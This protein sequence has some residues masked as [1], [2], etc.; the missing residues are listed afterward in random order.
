MS[1]Q[2]RVTRSLP[3]LLFAFHLAGCTSW[4]VETLPPTELI[5][6]KHPDRLR[7]EETDGRRVMFYGPDVQADSLRGRPSATATESRSVALDSVRSVST[8]RL[9]AGKTILLVLGVPVAVL[10]AVAVG[11]AASYSGL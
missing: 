8:P 4:H 9:N 10:L 2:L 7:V 6:Q 3:A 5:A 1:R 11:F